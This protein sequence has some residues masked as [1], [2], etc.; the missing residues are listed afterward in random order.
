MVDVGP[1]CVGIT[2]MGYFNVLLLQLANISISVLKVFFSLL[3]KKLNYL[4]RRVLDILRFCWFLL[5][6]FSC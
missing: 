1:L 3:Q 5:L 4:A 2:W 6:F